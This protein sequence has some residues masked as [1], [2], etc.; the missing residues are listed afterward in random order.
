[1]AKATKTE[2]SGN[3]DKYLDAVKKLEAKYGAGTIIVGNTVN[4]ELEVVPSGSLNLDVATGINGLPI[5]KL[6]EI[7]GPESSGKSTLTLHVISNFQ[8]LPGRCILIDFEHSFD[9]KYATTLGVDVD[10]ITKI[11]PDCMEDGYNIALELIKTGEVRLVIIDSH[12]AAIPK[13]VVEGNVGDATIGLQA[14]IN[15]VALGKIKPM[16]TPNRCT[17]IGV[18]QLRTKIGDY[19]DPDKPTGG[20]AWKFYSDMRLKVSK[21]LDKVNN[22][23]K[24]A[25]E[26]I[27]NKCAP[28]FGKAEF[29]INWGTGIDRLKEIIDQACVFGY[30]QAGGAGWF[31]IGETK[32]QGADKVKAFL[33]DNPEYLEQ[34]EKDIMEK[35]K[36]A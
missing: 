28:P 24:T 2:Q 19:G 15:S 26:V 29:C 22:L 10:G 12:T 5:G 30:I 33:L 32:M 14:R 6:I 25:V 8:K 11:Q 35:M 18:S 20:N 1:M 7:F 4:Q 21:V 27:K 36:G 9:K 17:M 13:V 31:T 3:Q 34:L 16:L 23:N